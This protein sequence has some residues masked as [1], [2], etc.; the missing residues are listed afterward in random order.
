MALYVMS[1]M[2]A[3]YMTILGAHMNCLLLI[4]TAG[5]ATDR[6]FAS[7]YGPVPIKAGAEH[8]LLTG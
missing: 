6:V 7:V 1:V 3:A 8:F 4:S 2:T 5:S